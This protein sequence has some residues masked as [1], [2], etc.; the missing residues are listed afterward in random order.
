[1]SSRI[2]KYDMSSIFHN[3]FFKRTKPLF[4]EQPKEVTA[5][6]LILR[7]KRSLSPVRGIDLRQGVKRTFDSKLLL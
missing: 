4:H 3:P 2:R 1:M 7:E 6:V 5:Q